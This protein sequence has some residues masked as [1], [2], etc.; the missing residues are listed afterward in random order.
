MVFHSVTSML[1]QLSKLIR[2]A[3]AS[4]MDSSKLG[5]QHFPQ[6]LVANLYCTS[7]RQFFQHTEFILYT[8][9]GEVREEIFFIV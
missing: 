6:L 7:K 1:H 4:H 8:R 2:H 3:F 5:V 9:F